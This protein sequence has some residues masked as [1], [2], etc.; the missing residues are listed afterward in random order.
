MAGWKFASD[1]SKPDEFW[2]G[3]H[4]WHAGH[5]SAENYTVGEAICVTPE[6][7]LPTS[8]C[9]SWKDMWEL[10]CLT[11]QSAETSSAAGAA[12]Q[13][14]NSSGNSF[15]HPRKPVQRAALSKSTDVN[16]LNRVRHPN[17]TDVQQK[18]ALAGSSRLG[19]D[20]INS[21]LQVK[22]ALFFIR[23][24]HN[25]GEFAIGIGRRTFKDKR[26]YGAH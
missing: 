13:P 4:T 5:P 7:S 26:S 22:G 9:L 8:P 19:Q 2:K 15:L 12:G 1:D 17:Y 24:G 25:E 21:K 16:E 20:Y 3:M 23:L 18:V 6:I 10:I 14:S 11:P